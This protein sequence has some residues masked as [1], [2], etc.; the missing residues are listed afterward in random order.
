MLGQRLRRCPNI[1]ATFDERL[2]FTD[3][4]NT[5]KTSNVGL[6]LV[7]LLRRWPNIKPTLS[8][9]IVLTGVGVALDV[10]GH[11]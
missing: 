1:E 7:H 6:M 8:R 9:C 4:V 11:W 3:S 2:V 5:L 10:S